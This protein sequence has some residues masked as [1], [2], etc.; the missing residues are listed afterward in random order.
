MASDRPLPSDLTVTGMDQKSLYQW[1]ANV[2]DL[3]NEIQTDHATFRTVVNANTTAVNAII[4]AAGTAS[5]TAAIA[6]VSSVA[7]AAPAA[8]TNSTAI[9][10]LRS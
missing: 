4:T 5:P 9:T 2:T 10:L 1:L 6:A 7:S 8:L 3:L